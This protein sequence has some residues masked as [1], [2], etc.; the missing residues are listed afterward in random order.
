MVDPSGEDGYAE[1]TEWFEILSA[2][3][4]HDDKMHEG[5]ASGDVVSVFVSQ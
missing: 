2:D 4:T 3:S 1:L 5:E